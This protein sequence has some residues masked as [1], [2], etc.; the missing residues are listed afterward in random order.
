MMTMMLSLS[1]LSQNNPDSTQR[2]G[3]EENDFCHM[4]SGKNYNSVNQSINAAAQSIYIPS[5]PHPVIKVPVVFHVLWKTS[6]QNIETKRLKSQIDVL[7][8]A[9][10]MGNKEEIMKKAPS[11]FSYFAAD[12]RI[13]FK[14]D[15][16]IRVKTDSTVFYM[17]NESAKF[18]ST[19]GSNV[20]DPEHKLNIWVC[21][22][23]DGLYGYA[24]FPGEDHSTDG[25][26]LTHEVVGNRTCDTCW[27]G[28]LGKGKI[29]V[30]EVGH[31]IGL[32]HIWGDDCHFFRTGGECA[33]SDEVTD[34]PNQLCATRG[35]PKGVLVSCGVRTLYM[36]YMNYVDN[37][38]MYM[39]TRGQMER[40]RAAI[41]L[42]RPKL[43]NR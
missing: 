8:K 25:V 36:N 42:Y 35:C 39:F 30:H 17:H 33:G 34:T 4:K 40:S 15:T 24:Q 12:M 21:E 20:I 41:K 2:F 16:V 32:L 7:N 14:L 31:W 28:P 23:E 26:V 38:C 6:N 1:T 18:D 10:R 13:E 5:K 27:W 3:K 22:L 9:F 43:L 19:G 29:A 37:D 11:Y